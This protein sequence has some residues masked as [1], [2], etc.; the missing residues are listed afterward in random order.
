MSSSWVA[1]IAGLKL[2]ELSHAESKTPRR[3]AGAQ[4]FPFLKGK[5]DR[6]RKHPLVAPGTLTTREENGM[7][8]NL[9]STNGRRQSCHSPRLEEN[10]TSNPD[11][12]RLLEKPHQF[13][14]T[15]TP[16]PRKYYAKVILLTQN[17][18]NVPEFTKSFSFFLEFFKEEPPSP[19]LVK[20]YFEFSL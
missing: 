6:H 17:V 19:S 1:G 5:C 2:E 12:L 18:V 14:W 4:Y 16:L 13:L 8:R 3:K 11:P 20:H 15:S 10:A 7:T 9:V